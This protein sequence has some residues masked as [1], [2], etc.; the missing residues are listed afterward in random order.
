MDTMFRPHKF[1]D[2]EKI[3]TLNYSS[4]ALEKS[5]S[6]V[7]EEARLRG[8]TGALLRTLPSGKKVVVKK[9]VMQVTTHKDT[10]VM[11]MI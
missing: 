8:S 4:Y 7:K 5:W 1:N 11:S 2:G 6:F 10:F 9:G 3:Y